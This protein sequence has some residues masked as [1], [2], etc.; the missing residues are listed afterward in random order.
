[1][2]KHQSE[3][4]ITLKDYLGTDLYAKLRAKKS[5]LEAEEKRKKAEEEARKREEQRQREKNKT[6][7]E[8]LNESNLDW[9]KFKE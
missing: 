4:K 8:L 2:M 5:A 7:E 9:R 6:F 1:M 3:E